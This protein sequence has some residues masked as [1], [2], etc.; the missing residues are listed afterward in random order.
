MT[1]NSRLRIRLEEDTGAWR[2]RLLV[3]R[4]EKPPVAKRILDFH[5]VLLREE[6]SGIL[7]WAVAGFAKLRKEFDEYG[8]FQI[9]EQ[10]QYRIDSLLAESESLRL[11]VR[12]RIEQDF[13]GNITTGEF[14]QAYAEFCADKGWNP[15]ST[16]MV[17]R[18]ATD[19]M[20]ETWQT[21]R[22]HSIERDGKKSNRGWRNV[23][24]KRE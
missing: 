22:T 18:K 20:L 16:T 15:L 6:G 13:Y 23:S 21:P 9:S 2:R 5:K 12:Q 24:L 8:D 19:L 11:F 1:C 10:Q 4:Y 7:L 3:I 17:E 14:V